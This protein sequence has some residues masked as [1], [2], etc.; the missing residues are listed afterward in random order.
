MTE[1]DLFRR[2]EGEIAEAIKPVLRELRLVDAADY[3]AYLR[4]EQ[5]QHVTDIFVSSTEQFFAP[6]F[7][8]YR[9]TGTASVSWSKLPLIRLEAGLST[10]NASYRF[11]IHMRDE[12]A[13]I[14][15]LAIDMPKDQQ[16]ELLDSVEE[17]RRAILINKVC[18]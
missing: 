17:L 18:K 14:E 8:T 1:Q 13:N 6:G 11:A 15:M 9:E 3:I 12:A 7:L 2:L 4:F 5:H 10:P 16:N